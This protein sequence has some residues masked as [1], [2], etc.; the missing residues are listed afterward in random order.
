MIDPPKRRAMPRARTALPVPVAPTMP[1]INGGLADSGAIQSFSRAMVNSHTDKCTNSWRWFRT[2][3]PDIPAIDRPSENISACMC[4]QDEHVDASARQHL[5]AL[6][7]ETLD[8][9]EQGGV[10]FADE[11]RRDLILHSGR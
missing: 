8:D 11:R 3:E 5:V 2:R 7:A 9:A 10:P 4:C 1:A 6:L